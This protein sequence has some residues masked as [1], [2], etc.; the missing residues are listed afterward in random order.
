M[1]KLILSTLFINLSAVTFAQSITLTPNTLQN[2]NS[3]GNEDIMATRYA[4]GGG[5]YPIIVGRQANGTPSTPSAVTNGS[6]L[7]LLGGRGYTGAAFTGISSG[8]IIFKTTENWT[9]I[10]NGSQI[11]FGTTPN[12]TTSRRDRMTI[13]HDGNVGIGNFSPTAKLHVDGDF[14]LKKKILLAGNGGVSNLNRNGASVISV[15]DPTLPAPNGG[16]SETINSIADGV[17]GMILYVYPR[18]GT[19]ITLVNEHAGS[20]AANRIITYTATN[21]TITNNGGCTLIYDGAVQRWRM[22]SVAN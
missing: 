5:T 4:G 7:L 18:Q 21:V 8:A 22:I 6:N 16:G 13:S 20:T 12:G 9:T 17:D 11:V 3:S 1:K 14:A 10:A 2:S 15:A 19:S